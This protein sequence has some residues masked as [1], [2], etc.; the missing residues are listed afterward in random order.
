MKPSAEPS[1][2]VLCPARHHWPP[3]GDSSP[4]V[5]RLTVRAGCRSRGRVIHVLGCLSS[6]RWS[7]LGHGQQHRGEE[8]GMPALFHCVS[9]AGASLFYESENES[10]VA[11][12]C[13]T[14]CD[15]MD[16]SLPG[17]SVHGISQARIL[18]WVAISFSRGSSRPRDRTP[19]SHIAGRRFTV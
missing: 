19:V 13:P 12:L 17:S 8:H 1:S 11:Q 2:S 6:P 7:A 14:L 5:W 3:P 4:G 9:H 16:C 18:E 15:P 10:E